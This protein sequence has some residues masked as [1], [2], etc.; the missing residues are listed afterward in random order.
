MSEFQLIFGTGP[1]GQA[2]A[3]SL[4]GGGKT[5]KMV[6]RSGSRPSD[7]PEEV[8]IIPGDA[9]NPEF[10]QQVTRGAAVV[11]QCA[12]PPYQ[13][14]VTEF[15]ALQ[16]AILEGAAANGAK[17][18]VG[19]NLYMYGDTDGQPLHE[20]LPYAAQT[21]KGRVRAEMS[22]ALLAAH[23]AGKV[24]VAM[25]RGSD[26][27]GPGVLKS[28]LGERTILPALQGK[29]AEIT[30]SPDQ[31]HSFTYINDFGAAMSILGERDEALGQAW[32]VPNAPILTQREMVTRFFNEIGLPVKIKSIGK[33][34]LTFGGLFVPEARE[35]VEMM[36]EFEK[37]FVVDAS[38]FIQTFGD[39]ATP[40]EK[41]VSKT[42]DWYRAYLQ[43]N[44]Q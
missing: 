6:N 7:L 16:A 33:L 10:T 5:I 30:G 34:T 19:E 15:P 42:I 13:K 14:W 37:P 24:R 12:Q 20:E 32:H 21:R 2:V 31:P 22:E 40:Y 39:I 4:L 26:F 43:P 28:S 17:L 38:K 35:I 23:R 1:L 41:S 9:Y 27:F 18:I 3:R 11:Y 25:A 29:A 36:Y 44:N 8:E